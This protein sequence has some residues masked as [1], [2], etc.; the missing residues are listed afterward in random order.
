LKLRSA[1]ACATLLLAGCGQGNLAAELEALQSPDHIQQ[2]TAEIIA[3]DAPQSVTVSDINTREAD[4][5]AAAGI[6]WSAR[7]PA[8]EFA[9]K[10]DERIEYPECELIRMAATTLDPAAAG[11]A[12]VES[13]MTRPE[14][15]AS[16][17]PVD[18]IPPSP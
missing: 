11:E 9:C 7:S 10:A 16:G 14:Q 6:E 4:G 17:A 18:V 2:K 13:P 15:D 3:P 1:I 5:G 8:G 12:S